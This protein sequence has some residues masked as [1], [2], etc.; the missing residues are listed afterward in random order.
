MHHHVVLTILRGNGGYLFITTN[1][2]ATPAGCIAIKLF[3]ADRHIKGWT[4]IDI[5]KQIFVKRSIADS[6]R[7]LE[8]EGQ[9]VDPLTVGECTLHFHHSIGNCY[10]DRLI[11]QTM[12]TARLYSQQIVSKQFTIFVTQVQ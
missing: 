1:L 9:I 8:R 10:G 3:R 4:F 6:R 11:W 7:N 12:Y 5:S 2:E